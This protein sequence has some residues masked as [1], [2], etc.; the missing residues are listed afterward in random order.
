MSEIGVVQR[1]ISI[2]REGKPEVATA[3]YCPYCQNFNARPLELT[4]NPQLVQCQKC[5]KPYIDSF[6]T[7]IDAEEIRKFLE[8]KRR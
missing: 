4:L 5:G 1:I 2:V 6:Q 3:S 8:E 7:H